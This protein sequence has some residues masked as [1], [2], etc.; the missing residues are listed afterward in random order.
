MVHLISISLFRSCKALM[1]GG[2]T[3]WRSRLGF[4]ERICSRYFTSIFYRYSFHSLPSVP[5]S[6]QTYILIPFKNESDLYLISPKSISSS[7]I[8]TAGL[9]TSS[10]FSNCLLASIKHS[11]LLSTSA[12]LISVSN[13]AEMGRWSDQRIG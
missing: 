2:F 4:P 13:E 11:F 10:S 9:Q 1:L 5:E 8:V 3:Y 7:S 12:T 6:H